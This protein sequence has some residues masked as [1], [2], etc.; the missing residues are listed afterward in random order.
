M[1]RPNGKP[2]F[3]DPAASLLFQ[4]DAVPL[5]DSAVEEGPGKELCIRFTSSREATIR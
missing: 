3:I 5:R 2:S 1:L 4:R